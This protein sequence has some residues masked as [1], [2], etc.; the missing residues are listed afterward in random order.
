MLDEPSLEKKVYFCVGCKLYGTPDEENLVIY[1][2]LYKPRDF[3]NITEKKTLCSLCY[4]DV[5]INYHGR[6]KRVLL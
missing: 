6:K 2:S 4:Y 1:R 3:E 5:T